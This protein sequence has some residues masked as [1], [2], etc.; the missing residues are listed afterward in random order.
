MLAAGVAL[1]EK[2]D[3]M[4]EYV[5]GGGFKADKRRQGRRAPRGDR[6]GAARSWYEAVGALAGELDRIEDAQ[7]LAEIKK[8]EAAKGQSYYYRYASFK[9][10][11]LLRV[12]RREPTK[13]GPA[14]AET[15]AAISRDPGPTPRPR[16]PSSTRASPVT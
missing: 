16:A 10:N 12:A 15:K 4:C 8:H 6:H 14:L 11:Q 7:V 3:A 2:R 1:N 5:K 9:T 13:L